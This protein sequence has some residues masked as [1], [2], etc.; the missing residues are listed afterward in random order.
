MQLR[1]A[2]HRAQKNPDALPGLAQ[3]AP[4][5]AWPENSSS[6]GPANVT[7]K[8]PRQPESAEKDQ[9]SYIPNESNRWAA[10]CSASSGRFAIARG[11]KLHASG[12]APA[13]TRL[14]SAHTR[15]GLL[16]VFNA[17]DRIIDWRGRYDQ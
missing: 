10:M 5:L 8:A 7:E 14:A 4:W 17:P 3:G 11:E 16:I 13:R 1:V 9:L 15:D 12:Q 2:T 6:S